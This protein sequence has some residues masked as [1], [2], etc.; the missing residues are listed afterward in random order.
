[1]SRIRPSILLIGVFV[2]TPILAFHQ[3]GLFKEARESVL[4]LLEQRLILPSDL[5][6]LRFLN[7]GYYTLMAFISAWV[8]MSLPRQ[9]HRFAFMFA[10]A[11]LTVTLTPVLAFNGIVFE[12]ISGIL[13][14]LGAG[15]L[16]LAFSGSERGTRVQRFRQFFVG[17]L[18][19]NQFSQLLDGSEPVKL[20]SKRE[21]SS[22][23]CRLLNADK[24]S[25]DLDPDQMELLS[26]AFMKSVSEFLVIKGGYLDVCN[27][28]GI[29]A[30]FGF[31]V[32]DTDHALNACKVGMA[33]REHLVVLGAELEKRWGHKPQVG[34]GISSGTAVCGLMGY[35]DFQ[36]YSA[37]GEPP[38]L[39]RRLCNMNGVYGST[40]LISA[41]TFN[42]LKAAVEVRPMELIAAPGQTSVSEVYE[43]LAEKG[44]L[45]PPEL[46]ARDAFWEGVVALR[47]GDTKAALA[48]LTAASSDEKTDPPLAYFIER[49]KAVSSSGSGKRKTDEL[50]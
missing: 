40:V 36:F 20:N 27:A 25:V 28:Q 31:P 4:H 30:Q 42:I 49:A 38:D 22:L 45:T 17:R 26:S 7:Y 50:A 23:T 48:K 46:S 6:S 8:C 18:S 29:T 34:V 12:P 44:T 5:V 21:I 41:R 3:F 15:L 37:L 14:I 10:L 2:C 33:L 35:R 24:L 43:L 13:A 39:S 9:W 1:M 11:F 16:G 19:A 32:S 47:K